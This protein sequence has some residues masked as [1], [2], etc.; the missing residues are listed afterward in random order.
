MNSIDFH[1]RRF[2]DCKAGSR[3]HFRLVR[4]AIRM[5][6]NGLLMR[7]MSMTAP[8]LWTGWKQI[9]PTARDATKRFSLLKPIA[10]PRTTIIGQSFLKLQNWRAPF[11]AEADL[12]LN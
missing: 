3:L 12:R 2:C 4:T 6:W 11:A 7:A 9:F 10:A 8:V 5:V 1:R